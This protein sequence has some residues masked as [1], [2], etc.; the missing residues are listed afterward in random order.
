MAED[1]ISQ[2]NVSIQS[3]LNLLEIVK[4]IKNISLRTSKAKD[5]DDYLTDGSGQE[6]KLKLLRNYYVQGCVFVDKKQK[7]LETIWKDL[8]NVDIKYEDVNNATSNVNHKH[9]KWKPIYIKETENNL[10]DIFVKI[11]MLLQKSEAFIKFY[12]DDDSFI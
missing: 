2:F 9:A 3:L 1:N 8:L 4:D 10:D 12:K 5:S 6:L 7:E 11:Q